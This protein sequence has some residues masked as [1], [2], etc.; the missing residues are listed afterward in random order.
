MRRRGFQGSLLIM[1]GSGGC[2]RASEAPRYAVST[3][4]SVL[5]GG[6]V[7]CTNLGAILG[8]K[9]IISTDIGGTTFLVGLIVD[10]KPVTSTSMV[11]NQHRSRLRW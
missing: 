8:H 3:L 2:V 6:I 11:I 4:G 7:G 9:N 10:G 5:A 1:Q